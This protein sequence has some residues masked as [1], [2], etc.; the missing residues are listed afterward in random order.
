MGNPTGFMEYPREL[1][2]RR[3]V[4]E[5]LKDYKEVDGPVDPDLS[6]RQATRCMTCGTPFCHSGCPLGNNI[7]E[8]NQAAGESNW[9]RAYEVLRSTNNFPEFTGRICP[10]P[11]EASCVLGINQSPVTIE[12][13]EKTI[14][15]KAFEDGLVEPRIPGFR[16]GKRIAV[17]GSG[18]A[19]LAAASQLNTAGHNVTVYE[20]A[21]AAGGILRFGIP[22]FK[23]EK[24][25]I[26]RRVKLMEAEGVEFRLGKEISS[27]DDVSEIREGCDAMLLAMGSTVP[28][29]LTVPGRNLKGIHFAMDFLSRQNRLVQGTVDDDPAWSARGKNVVILGGGDTGADCLGTSLR[30]GAKSVVQFEI[31]AK[32]PSDRTPSMPWPLW[33]AILRTSTSHEEGGDRQWAVLT[34]EFIDDGKGCVAGLKVVSIEWK[35]AEG[36]S[37]ELPQTSRIVPCDLV[38]LAM[39]F[40][41]PYRQG[42]IGELGVQLDPRGVVKTERYQTSLPG[43]FAA[44]DARRGQS[45]VVWAIHEGR[46]AARFIDQFLQGSSCLESRETGI[47]RTD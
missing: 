1:P 14:I 9:K 34:K 20:K 32:P 27:P 46:E 28:R 19:G 29:D 2:S 5:R 3:S 38:L 4:S 39:G 33:P 17:I 13:L 44:G 8:F 45:L 43:V 7:P 11:C 35:E 22:D 10:A 30:H 21:E 40:T 12:Y 37:V 26:D 18:P 24:S 31:L 23:L 41:G 16:T 36:Y 42:I 25:V 47:L 15:E 6:A